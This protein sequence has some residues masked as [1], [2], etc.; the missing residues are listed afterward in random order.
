MLLR[1]LRLENIRSYEHLSLGFGPGSTMLSGDIGSG[2]SSLLL[3]VEFALF[4]AKKSE[5]PAG[6]LLRHGEKEG[7]VELSF[8]IEGKEYVIQRTLRR[9]KDSVKQAKGFLVAEG[10]KDELMPEELRARVIH[11]LGYPD[12]EASKGKD[13][14]FRYTVYTPQEAMKQILFEDTETRKDTL[15]KIFGID[16]YKRIRE[17]GELYL[18]TLRARERAYDGELSDIASV[19]EHEK[20]TAERLAAA[21]TA[22]AAAEGFLS[23]AKDAYARAKEEL[24]AL[25]ERLSLLQRKAQEE[26]VARTKHKEAESRMGE[27]QEKS[28]ALASER[29]RTLSEAESIRVTWRP[30]EERRVRAERDAL[31]AELEGARRAREL[32]HQEE[33]FRKRELSQL[34]TDIEQFAEREKHLSETLSQFASAVSQMPEDPAPAIASAEEEQSR[35]RDELSLLRA[36]LSRDDDLLASLSGLSECPTCRQPIDDTHRAHL[37]AEADARKRK[38]SARVSSLSSSLA[39]LGE[40]ISTLRAQASDRMLQEERR[41]NIMH[42]KAEHEAITKRLSA[43][44]GQKDACEKEL[45]RIAAALASGDDGG[46][47][48]KQARLAALDEELA[49]MRE[50]ALFSERKKALLSRC[51]QIDAELSA[52]AAQKKRLAQAVTGLTATL[53]AL[54]SELAGRDALAASRP[55]I[56]AKH[57]AANAA[58]REASVRM[59]EARK[60]EETL[61][62]ELASARRELSAKEAVERKRQDAAAAQRW[63]SAYLLPVAAIIERRVMGA[64]YTEFNEVFQSWFAVLIEDE[65]VTVRLDEEF[66]PLLEQNGYETTVEHLSGGERQALALAYRLALNKV[67]NELISHIRTK[68]LLILDEPTEGFSSHQMDRIRDVLA[69]LSVAQVLLVSHEQK[70]EGFVDH[71]VRIQKRQHASEVV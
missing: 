29:E 41:K 71:V 15:R 60:E 9:T 25:D 63:L 16:R 20:G 65:S 12:G 45:A 10:R 42:Q 46:L 8:S 11:L 39:S 5:L 61:A 35:L 36:G 55:S 54:A 34:S 67:I 44:S 56:L 64:I 40:R 30:E 33:T 26:A 27:Y 4:G 47:A 28:A 23:T 70:L 13:L 19:R 53:S 32:L 50:E 2:K 6:L 57:D 1:H 7:M 59:A 69:E 48:A 38:L 18:K 14:I 31:S 37:S 66:C 49:R 24:S 68:E 51:A 43:L 52:L 21:K 17:N 22:T 62:R 3:A 58:F